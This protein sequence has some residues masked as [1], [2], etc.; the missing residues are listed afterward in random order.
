M[1]LLLQTVEDGFPESRDAV[2]PA[3]QEYH[4]FRD[5]LSSIDGVVIYKDRTVIPPSLRAY[6]LDSLHAAHHCV[7]TMTAR[8][9]NSVFWPGITTDIKRIRLICEDCNRNAP[10]QPSAPP[11]PFVTPTYPFQ[12]ICT[13]YFQYTGCHY[14]IM[15]DRYSNWLQVEI[16]KGGSQGLINDLRKMFA[17]FGI[18]EECASDGGP[19][20][21]AHATTKFL[22]DWGVHHRRSSVGFPH[23][24]AR[25]EIGVKSAK[26]LIMSH[27][28]PNG[29]LDTDAFQ[30]AILQ[31]R[32]TPDAVTKVSPAMCL[33]VRPTRDFIPIHPG[34]YQPHPTWQKTLA[35]REEALKERHIRLAERW[36][37][38]T[39]RLPPLIVGDKVRIQ[40]LQ[41]N[42]PLKWDRTGEV[43][44]VKQ[45]D[46]YLVRVDGSRLP[47]LRNR[48]HLRRIQPLHSRPAPRVIDDDLIHFGTPLSQPAIPRAAKPVIP[49]TL[50]T[51]SHDPSGD[52]PP[53]TTTPC[54]APPS[55]PTPS[56]P[57]CETPAPS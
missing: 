49:P 14:L 11:A 35:A 22:T 56:L 18:P 16:S 47:T 36:N 4:P 5:H 2:S 23:S 53:P 19:E 30:R 43:V 39:K 27:T 55:T 20:F 57:P 24:N 28:G 3:L 8:A 50:D 52:T 37:E 9:E 25:A 7:S 44:E 21:T 40:N 48:K 17:T 12:C 42:R 34:K 29:S 41:G 15:V 13:D 31:H 6:V 33:F 51:D 32:N 10:S 54:I 1:L 45:F 46:Q 26:R 38:R